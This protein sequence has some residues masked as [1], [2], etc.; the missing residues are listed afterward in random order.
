MNGTIINLLIDILII[1]FLLSGTFFVFS[2]A[3]GVVRFKNVYLR[4]HAATKSS[5]LGVA[6]LM[7]GAFLFMLNEHGIVSGKLL[8][9]ILFVL[10][11]APVSAHMIGRA[12]Y[13]SGIP[14]SEEAVQDDYKETFEE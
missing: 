10:I 4:L 7:L 6:G 1:F 5:T 3:L 14:L 8:L 2:G 9:G 12:A 11:T 13:K